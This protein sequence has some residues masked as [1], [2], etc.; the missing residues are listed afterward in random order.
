MRF[1]KIHRQRTRELQARLKQMAS[2]E[3]F[4][5][6]SLSVAGASLS[7]SGALAARTFTHV[8]YHLKKKKTCVSFVRQKD[9]IVS[10]FGNV[11]SLNHCHMQALLKPNLKYTHCCIVRWW[12]LGDL[13]LLVQ[14]SCHYFNHLWFYFLGL[15]APLPAHELHQTVD[16][17]NSNQVAREV[18]MLLSTAM[19][20]C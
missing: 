12:V 11:T 17:P 5:T 2:L 18:I 6:S 7:S 1:S 8:R 4:P 19:Q 15:W 16:N 20:T 3:K 14:R 10:P 13:R 9:H